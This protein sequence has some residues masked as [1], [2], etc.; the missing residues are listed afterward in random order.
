MA[1]T[2]YYIAVSIAESVYDL[3]I[4]GDSFYGHLR[5]EHGIADSFSEKILANEDHKNIIRSLMIADILSDIV[6][7]EKGFKENHYDK[8][9][10]SYG[11]E[12]DD[13][14]YDFRMT[15]HIVNCYADDMI[16]TSV[17]SEIYK[18]IPRKKFTV[19]AKFVTYATV[20]V[21]DVCKE[22]AMEVAEHLDGADFITKDDDGDW[23]IVDAELSE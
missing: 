18:E 16:R 7:D 14:D 8:D 22:A 12:P 15:D 17:E 21:E 9:T 10:N 5:D 13:L 11:Y 2:N 20:E 23:E 4:E 19:T 3:Q 6:A 1:Q